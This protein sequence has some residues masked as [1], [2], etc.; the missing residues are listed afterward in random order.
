MSEIILQHDGAYLRSVEQLETVVEL[1]LATCKQFTG[2]LYI[3]IC[4]WC[5]LE[6][7]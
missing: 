1:P 2:L 5:R 6:K 4:V 7:M 3:T